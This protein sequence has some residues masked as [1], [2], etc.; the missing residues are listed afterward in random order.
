MNTLLTKA[1]LAIYLRLPMRTRYLYLA[2]DTVDAATFRRMQF[3]GHV[4]VREIMDYANALGMKRPTQKRAKEMA[5]QNLNAYT[6]DDEC[7]DNMEER[8]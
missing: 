5:R 2:A 1:D 3:E 4:E 8:S 7:R 6:M